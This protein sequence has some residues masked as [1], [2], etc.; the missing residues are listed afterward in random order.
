[1]QVID[2]RAANDSEDTSG[3]ALRPHPRRLRYAWLPKFAG[4]EP[5]LA[6]AR[7]ETRHVV[8]ARGSCPL[9]ISVGFS[10]S[11]QSFFLVKYSSTDSTIRKIRTCNPKRLRAS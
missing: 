9:E 11:C 2:A 8:V 7:V 10:M 3:H 4:A 5:L 6:P 1:G